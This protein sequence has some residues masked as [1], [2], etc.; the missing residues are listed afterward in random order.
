M[1]Q[2][3]FYK[4]MFAIA[5]MATAVISCSK[6]DAQQPINNIDAEFGKF[7]KELTIFDEEKN[8]SAVLLVGSDD[9][10]VLNMWTADNFTLIPIKEGQSLADVFESNAPETIDENAE[11]IENDED[12]NVAAS[13]S[14]KFVSKKLQE[15]V[16]NVALQITDP[17]DESMRGWKYQSHFSDCFGKEDSENKGLVTCIVEG[18]NVFHKGYFGI[19]YLKYSYSNWSTLVSEWTR[20]RNNETVIKS[21]RC[22][23]MKA[24]RKYK[25]NNESVTIEFEY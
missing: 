22:Y 24:R 13:I 17:Y 19:S 23:E 5:A 11:V 7:T 9:E 20:I 18:H 8:N 21:V 6:E 10:S 15:G 25:G 16:K 4:S 1:T 12:D 2:K 3:C 14:T